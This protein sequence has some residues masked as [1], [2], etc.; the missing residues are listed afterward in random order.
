[1]QADEADQSCSTSESGTPKS[2]P[3]TNTIFVV[4]SLRAT[5]VQAE[6]GDVL[7]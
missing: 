5:L 7:I 3:M 2:L 1:M 4:P 6:Q